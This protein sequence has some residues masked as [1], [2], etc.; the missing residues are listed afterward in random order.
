MVL[1][2][3]DGTAERGSPFAEFLRAQVHRI[4]ARFQ[5]AAESPDSVPDKAALH[6]FLVA[7]DELSAATDAVGAGTQ[8]APVSPACQASWSSSSLKAESASR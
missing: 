5:A 3:P 4:S 1:M 7:L 6:R 2:K 8:T